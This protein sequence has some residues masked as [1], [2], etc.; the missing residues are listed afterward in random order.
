DSEI[1]LKLAEFDEKLGDEAQARAEM[2]RYVELEKNSLA[3]LEKLAGFYH[4]RARFVDEAA[5]RERMIAAAPAGERAPVLRALIE[6]ARRQR[7]EKYQRPDYFRRLIASDNASF[8][9]VKQFVDHL[10]ETK[11]F[12]VALGALRQH[13]SAFPN[14]KNY[15]LE[16]EVDVLL[17]LNRGG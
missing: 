7:L 17:K 4:R 12:N 6:T 14:E 2:A 15:F 1:E 11:A 9:V 10:I 16:K 8:D 13:K 3:A 5:T